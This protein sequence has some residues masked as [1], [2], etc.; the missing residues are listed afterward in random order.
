[1]TEYQQDQQMCNL[2]IFI[3]NPAKLTYILRNLYTYIVIRLKNVLLYYWLLTG[4]TCGIIGS[5]S[6]LPLL[7]SGTWQRSVC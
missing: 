2:K 6:L 1:M 5:V 7:P 3:W 4:N